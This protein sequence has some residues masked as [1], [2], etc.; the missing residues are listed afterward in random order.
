MQTYDPTLFYITK[1]PRLL[2]DNQ[3]DATNRPYAE[4]AWVS[5]HTDDVDAYSTSES[6]LKEI[7]QSHDERWKAKEVRSNFLLGIKRVRKR[8]PDGEGGVHNDTIEMTMT[9][10]VEGMYSA[11]ADYIKDKH[12]PETPMPTGTQL[13]KNKPVKAEEAERMRDRGYLR[14]VGM[15]LWAARNCYPECMNGCSQLGS[16]MANPS[17]EAWKAAMHMIAYIYQNRH[18]GIKF[19][20]ISENRPVVLSDASNKPDPDD[21]LCRYGYFL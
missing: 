16:V 5:V 11:F 14:A 6:L 3:C 12:R 10:Y 19:S 2:E 21:G 18:Q 20:K 13:T 1:G 7:F 4:E 17:E 8:V 9:P 15:L